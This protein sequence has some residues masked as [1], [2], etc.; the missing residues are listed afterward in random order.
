MTI[1]HEDGNEAHRL[2]VE[3]DR[4]RLYVQLSCEDGTGPWT[5]LAVDRVSR[6]YAAAQ[7]ETKTAATQA[8]AL[9][10][11]SFLTADWTVPYRPGHSDH[12]AR[13]RFVRRSTI[14]VTANVEL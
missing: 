4:A 10:L 5:V 11:R 9:A 12:P 2:R 8:A 3:H 1:L 14:G 13:R 7:A 6:R